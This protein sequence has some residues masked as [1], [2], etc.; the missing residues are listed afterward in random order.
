MIMDLALQ[1]AF[2]AEASTLLILLAGAILIYWSFREK[3]LLPWIAGFSAYGL[4]KFFS[5]LSRAHQPGAPWHTL[6]YVAFILAVGLFAGTVFLYVY[7][8]KLLWPA[9]II[10]AVALGLGVAHGVAPKVLLLRGAFEITWRVVPV[11][12]SVQMVRF[13]W[14]RPNYGRWVL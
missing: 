13:T 14:G 10:L 5:A 1:P 3:Y 8:K 12:A 2:L 7:R 6:A 9:G 11:L 4:A